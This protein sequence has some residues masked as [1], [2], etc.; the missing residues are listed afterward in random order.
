MVK[1]STKILQTYLKLEEV[2]INVRNLVGNLS[3]TQFAE[4]IDK[5]KQNITTR[6]SYD[7]Y[8]LFDE[9]PRILKYL[10]ENNLQDTDLYFD[11]SKILNPHLTKSEVKEVKISDDTS[12]EDFTALNVRGEV[13]V[14][15]GYGSFVD[16]D[17]VTGKCL[18]PTKTLREYG[19]SRTHTEV[20]YAQGD[21]MSPEIKSGDALLVDTSQTEIIDGVMYAFNYDG[22]PMCKR[23]QKIGKEI[24]AISSNP[25]FDPFIIDFTC[26]FNIVGRVVGFMRPVF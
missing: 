21:S 17:R 5:K 14:S 2:F 8:L 16:N 15:C 13:G 4:I 23:L 6:I 12:D 25:L 7:G 26:Q 1:K 24:K 3:K 20:V 18:V 19:A 22:Q 10:S 9:V 11:L